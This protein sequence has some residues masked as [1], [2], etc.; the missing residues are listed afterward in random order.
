MDKNKL[1]VYEMEDIIKSIR[2]LQEHIRFLEQAHNTHIQT[3]IDR[4][5]LK[6]G[7][8]AGTDLYSLKKE[9]LEKIASNPRMQ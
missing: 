2:K 5:H 9:F 4:V 1:T 8:E 6:F 3:V 7:I